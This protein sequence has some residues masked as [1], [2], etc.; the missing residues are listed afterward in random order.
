MSERTI[1]GNHK[2]LNLDDRFHIENY[3]NEGLQFNEI[4]ELVNRNPKTISREVKS[5]RTAKCK[6][7]KLRKSK[8]AHLKTCTITNLCSNSYCKRNVPCVKCKLR[9]CSQYCDRYVPGT[10]PKLLKPPYVCNGCPFP[11]TCGYD[12]MYYRAKYA[13]DVYHEAMSSTRK[14]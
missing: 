8:C 3:L 12:K 5:H 1:T 10:C 11:R 4:A 7:P 13:D 6:D 14:G 9:T 2:N